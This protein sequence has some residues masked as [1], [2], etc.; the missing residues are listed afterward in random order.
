MEK[1]TQAKQGNVIRL[2]KKIVSPSIASETFIKLLDETLSI[3]FLLTALIWGATFI[4]VKDAIDLVSDSIG[5]A[6][7]AKSEGEDLYL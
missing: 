2:P 5:A 3:V 4:V 1:N 7:I 6:I